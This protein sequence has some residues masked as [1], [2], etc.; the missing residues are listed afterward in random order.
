MAVSLRRILLRGFSSMDIPNSHPILLNVIM[1]HIINQLVKKHPGCK[2]RAVSNI[3]SSLPNQGAACLQVSLA[4]RC[5]LQAVYFISKNKETRW[6]RI[7][8]HKLYV[9]SL[10][11]MQ[12]VSQ[13]AVLLPCLRS[14]GSVVPCK[15]EFVA[16]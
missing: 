15:Y 1:N 13:F 16:L 10:C 4:D 11:I 7:Y 3:K 2:D 5:S 9:D 8:T 12:H 14:L 6:R